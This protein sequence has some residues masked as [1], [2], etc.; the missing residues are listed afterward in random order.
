MDGNIL[1]TAE[2]R[3]LIELDEAVEAVDAA[4]V[5]KTRLID[6]LKREV[7]AGTVVV[8]RVQRLNTKFAMRAPKPR[9]AF[10]LA[11]G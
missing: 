11:G 6:D 2:E 9:A 4:I 10:R 8:H 5:H 1:N 3:K 7:H